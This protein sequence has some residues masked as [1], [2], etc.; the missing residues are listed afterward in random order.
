M[1]QRL[2]IIGA[3]A[4][5]CGLARA[6]A[7]RIG[8]PRMLVRSQA[9]VARLAADAGAATL[10]TT[11]LAD[12]SDCDVVVEAVIEDEAVKA[13]VLRE[14][15]HTIAS[16]ALLMTTTSSLSINVL[17]DA[18]G[19]A[20]RFVGLHV[21]TPVQKMPLVE[22]IFPD[23]A[24]DDTRRRAL[25]LCSQLDKTAVVVPDT[26]GFIV[27]RV[28]FPFLFDA[29]RF[30][31][32]EGVT[33]ETLDTCVRLGASHPMGPLALLDFVGLDVA[34]AIAEQIGIDVPRRV[35]HL[36]ESGRLGR[37]AGAGFYEYE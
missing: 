19:R 4:V 5:A 17:A 3:G 25:E 12:L 34:V 15:N 23:Q 37:K 28:L 6:A 11:R 21:F 16:D 24:S 30:L 1:A 32:V 14:V 2:G 7:P 22:L 10:A 20:E 13:E 31:D 26:P 9:T 29:V 36:V 8:P 33:P 18:S 35:G 27:N